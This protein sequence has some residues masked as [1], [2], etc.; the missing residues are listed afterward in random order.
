[1]PLRVV[2]CGEIRY[3]L[4]TRSGPFSG[5]LQSRNLCKVNFTCIFSS[6]KIMTKIT[7]MLLSYGF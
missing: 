3:D 5:I 6:Y 1:M 4:I 7:I 2:L